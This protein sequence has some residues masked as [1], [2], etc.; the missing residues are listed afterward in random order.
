MHHPPTISAII[1]NYRTWQDTTR[2]IQALLQQTIARE[3]E[4]LVVDNH[5]RNDSIGSLR[6]RW[7]SH[8]QVRLLEA[9]RNIGY[10]RGNN[11]GAAFARGEY[12]LIVNPDTLLLPE[13]LERMLRFLQN[14]PDVGIVGP[15]L[16]FPDGNIRDSFRT[17]PSPKDV[18]IK[19]TLLRTL[20][21]KRLR[22]YL[23]KDADPQRTRDVDWV[24]GACLFLRRDL[25]Q[26]LGGFDPRFFLFFEDT[27]LCRR[28]LQAG[29]R[30]V[31]FPEAEALDGEHRL[32]SG[33]LFSLLTKRT[34]RIH[35]TSALKYFWKWQK[36]TDALTPP[37]R[38]L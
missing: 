27:D 28:C 15:R 29:K 32:S 10:G 22:T 34:V 33:G 21:S 19:R 8:P 6:N 2:C 12:L 26:E 31:Y 11:L 9:P 16:T 37:R 24:V 13:A 20:F 23:Q 17:F 7:R 36:A 3:L 35:I 1:L 38:V 30:V 4:I 14:H 18:F 25:F 5:S